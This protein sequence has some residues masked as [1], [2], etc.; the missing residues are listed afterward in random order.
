MLDTVP[1][2]V[3]VNVSVS[4]GNVEV[5]VTVVVVVAKFEEGLAMDQLGGE[6]PAEWGSLNPS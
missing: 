4:T 3:S 2:E 1:V 6:N 5:A